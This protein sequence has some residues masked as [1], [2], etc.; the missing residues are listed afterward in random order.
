MPMVT[1][2]RANLSHTCI[3][4]RAEVVREILSSYSNNNFNTNISKVASAKSGT[5]NELFDHVG[6]NNG[7]QRRRRARIM[8]SLSF[9]CCPS[10]EERPSVSAYVAKKWAAN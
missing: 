10:S 3:Y 1:S 5:L 4:D 6:L 7:T 2:Q 8:D 9:Y